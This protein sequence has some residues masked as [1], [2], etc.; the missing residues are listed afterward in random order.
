[1]TDR[2]ANRRDADL[3]D[4]ARARQRESRREHCR[5]MRENARLE[6]QMIPVQVGVERVNVPREI[7]LLNEASQPLIDTPHHGLTGPICR[8]GI[9]RNRVNSSWPIGHQLWYKCQ[10]QVISA[11]LC[12]CLINY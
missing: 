10:F 8:S 12:K 7:H 11:S 4:R 1:M 3:T 5:N 2:R 6:R 9:V